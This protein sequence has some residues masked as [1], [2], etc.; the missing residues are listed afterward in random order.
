MALEALFPSKTTIH[1]PHYEEFMLYFDGINKARNH[2]G[3]TFLFHYQEYVQDAKK[4]YSYTQFLEH[5]NRKYTKIKGSMK[6]E[7]DPGNE[8]YVDYA[9]KKP[10]M[11][12]NVRPELN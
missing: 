3:F 8:M 12:G 6:L 2:L 7:H 11:V 9:G 5:Y 4:P 1:N 10:Q